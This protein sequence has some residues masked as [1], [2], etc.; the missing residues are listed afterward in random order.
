MIDSAPSHTNTTLLARAIVETIPEPFLML[1]AQFRV[2]AASRSFYDSFHVDAEDTQD[3]SLFAL[4]NGQ[5]NLPALRAMLERIIV[6]RV[7]IDGFEVEREFPGIGHRTML[8]DA[9]KVPREPGEA[10]RILLAFRDVTARRAIERE[11]E[12]ILEQSEHLRRQQQVLLEEMQHRV[13]N[14]LQ[15]IAS[16]L[17][18][19][20]RA[21]S[22][23]ETRHHL[24]DAHQRVMSVAAVQQHLH[25]TA[26]VD[27]V[28]VSAYLTKL[29]SGLA[30]SMVA[31]GQPIAIKAIADEGMVASATAVSLGLIVTELVINALKYA[32]PVLKADALVLVTYEIDEADWK[33]VVSDNGV[34]KMEIESAA[35]DGGLGTTIVKAL[36]TQLGA[37]VEILVT[38]EGLTTAITRATFTSRMPQAA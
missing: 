35:A 28:E 12:A 2:L 5:W 21:V 18:L 27:K 31:E 37:Q 10:I 1:D 13:A 3:S 20:A 14:S 38:E 17:L 25:A 9:R 29:C 11:K 19:K 4:G 15:I 16:I 32:F 30:S 22:S 26:G 34:G 7:A 36:A 6:D 24:H 33:L 23:E 8:L